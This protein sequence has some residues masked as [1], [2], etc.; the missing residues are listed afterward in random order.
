MNDKLYILKQSPS[1]SSVVSKDV[2]VN[3]P[4][5]LVVRLTR[6]Y[7]MCMYIERYP[8]RLI[9]LNKTNMFGRMETFQSPKRAQSDSMDQSDQ[10]S[11]LTNKMKMSA[12][13]TLAKA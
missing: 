13:E 8:R 4:A 12:T 10:T 9:S 2:E 5:G 1:Q 7:E 6:K 11:S 3:E